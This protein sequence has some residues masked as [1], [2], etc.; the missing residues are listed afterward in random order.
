MKNH[1]EMFVST[2][3]HDH[4]NLAPANGWYIF[5][6][7][8]S[9]LLLNMLP[10]QEVFL[11]LRPDFV[12]LTIIYWTVHQPH[13]VGMSIAFGM[14]LL[15]DVSNAG[16]L[17]QHAL[18]YSIISYFSLI[19]HRRLLYFNPIQQAPQIG[20]ILLL[21]QLI[22]LIIGLLSGYRF[23]GL[24]YFITSITGML[25]WPLIT[26]SLGILRKPKAESDTL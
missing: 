13:R 22:I 3:Y 6:T 15:V 1:T 11:P 20:F 12:A 14:G 16:I 25:I 18:A 19:S 24:Y 21:M 7:L 5:A 9:A 8:F 10:L 26:Y 2:I 4:N 23:P 17:G